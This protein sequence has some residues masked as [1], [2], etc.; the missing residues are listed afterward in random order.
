MVGVPAELVTGADFIMVRAG[1]V[2]LLGNANDALVWSRINWRCEMETVHT[3]RGPDGEVWWDASREV[4]GAETGLK[5]DQARRALER[6][7]TAG[8][9]ECEE[10][11][12]GGNYD[13]TKSYRCHID[14]A[15]VPNEQ[16]TSAHSH[17]APVPTHTSIET[18]GDNPQ[19]DPGS[20]A[21]EQ[22]AGRAAARDLCDRLAQLI[23]ENGSKPRKVTQ[24]WLDAARLLVDRDGRSPQQVRNMIEWCQRDEFWRSN[25]LSMPTLREKYDQMR[26]KA[27][28]TPATSTV[29][30]GADL[31]A[32]AVRREAER[33]AATAKEIEQ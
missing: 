5:P 7:V 9:L 26:L 21:V 2:E 16:G 1:L 32:E 14:R 15:P 24:K 31:Y 4:I 19:T 22:T 25:I 27:M 18:S 30:T 12:L 29:R 11:R 28:A 33:N 6:L 23:V 17:R 13:R 10:H 3:H 8:Y 20:A